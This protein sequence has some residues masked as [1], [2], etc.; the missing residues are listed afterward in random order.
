VYPGDEQKTHL[1]SMA[2]HSLSYMRELDRVWT[3][4]KPGTDRTL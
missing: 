3:R 2:S 4:F 1:H